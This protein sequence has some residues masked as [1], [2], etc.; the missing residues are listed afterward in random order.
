MRKF[1]YY[2]IGLICNILSIIFLLFNSYTLTATKGSKKMIFK[3]SGYD[4]FL[5]IE[6]DYASPQFGGISFIIILLII[7]TIF[8]YLIIKKNHT[9]SLVYINLYLIGIEIALLLIGV[10]DGLDNIHPEASLLKYAYTTSGWKVNY[11]MSFGSILKIIFLILS[12][13]SIIIDKKIFN[14]NISNKKK[15]K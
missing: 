8:I 1:N 6:S 14:Y 5:C 3:Y 15:K 10:I 13:A 9:S 11:Y 2:I 7:L 4:A 12:F